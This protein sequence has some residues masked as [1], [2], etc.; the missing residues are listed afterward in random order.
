MRLISSTA[1]TLVIIHPNLHRS[2]HY[3]PAMQVFEEQFDVVVK[4]YHNDGDHDWN[5]DFP[6]T[7]RIDISILSIG[8]LRMDLQRI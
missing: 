2:L 1:T 8:T 7:E 5:C 4:K 3:R 6:E